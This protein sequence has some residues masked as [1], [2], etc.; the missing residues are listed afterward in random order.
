M[1]RNGTLYL[2]LKEHQVREVAGF[3]VPMLLDFDDALL[4]IEM[5]VVQPPYMLDF[6]GA[7][8]DESPPFESEEIAEWQASCAEVFEADWPRVKRAYYAFQRDG[9]TLNDLHPRNIACQ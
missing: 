1:P 5:E 8:L 7:Y 9:I 3:A 4:V 6:A 2:R